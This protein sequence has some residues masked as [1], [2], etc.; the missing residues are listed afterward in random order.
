MVIVT[1][2]RLASTSIRPLGQWSRNSLGQITIIGVVSGLMMIRI[3]W[4]PLN[5]PLWTLHRKA[6]E[7]VTD[8]NYVASGMKGLSK[9]FRALVESCG[10]IAVKTFELGIGR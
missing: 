6:R 1:G 2:F 8:A 4:T 3:C 7:R 10:A 5:D 9:P